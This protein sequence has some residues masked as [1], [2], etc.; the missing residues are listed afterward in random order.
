MY[1][2]KYYKLLFCLYLISNIAHAKI[3]CPTQPVQISSN[4]K[5]L[6]ESSMGQIKAIKLPNLKV[7]LNNIKNDLI[8][9]LPNAD[10]VFINQMIFSA[11][12]SSIRDDKFT[13]NIEKS[14]KIM[15]FYNSINTIKGIP[16]TKLNIKE[17]KQF[18]KDNSI[19][20]NI[21]SYNQS[22]GLIAQNISI[23]DLP[24]ILTDKEK[25]DLLNK[26]IKIQ[27]TK[28]TY[29]IGNKKS[30]DYAKQIR[31]FLIQNGYIISEMNQ[32]IIHETLI[33]SH[34]NIYPNAGENEIY[35]P[36]L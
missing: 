3:E 5:I 6:V 28:I 33:P 32:G 24:K 29:A 22:G 34:L 7:A 8:E 19:H 21:I 1:K 23:G 26:L 11:Y 12:C 18:S 35:I 4:S 25:Q 9:K 15:D 14:K 16:T 2:I 31:D 17:T 20:N 27:N 36:A 13:S 30:L 10:K